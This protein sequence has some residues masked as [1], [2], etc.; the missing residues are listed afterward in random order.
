MKNYAPT[1]SSIEYP[2]INFLYCEF[3]ASQRWKARKDDSLD[4]TEDIKTVEKTKIWKMIFTQMTLQMTIW[5]VDFRI[6]LGDALNYLI[7]VIY[8]SVPFMQK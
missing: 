1:A 4:Y 8:M 5:R 3:H 2:N 7:D 6:I